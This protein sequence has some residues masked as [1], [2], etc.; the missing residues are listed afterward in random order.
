MPEYVSNIMLKTPESIASLRERNIHG[1][2][3]K[4]FNMVLWIYLGVWVCFVI[5]ICHGSEFAKNAQDSEYA[6][7]SSSIMLEYA[8][9]CLEMK[10]EQLHML[11]SIY[12]YIGAFRI[13]HLNIQ[14][15]L[16]GRA[17]QK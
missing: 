10:L 14:N 6:W 16:R 15:G 11:S 9:I 7:V 5:R 4:V 2:F 8:W 3:V 13:K 12:R 1:A 17:L